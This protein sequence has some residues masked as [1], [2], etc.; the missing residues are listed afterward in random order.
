M[1]IADENVLVANAHRRLLRAPNSRRHR[2]WLSLPFDAVE[3]PLWVKSGHCNGSAEWLLYPQKRTLNERVEM[4][5]LCHKRTSPNAAASLRADHE[6]DAVCFDVAELHGER[7]S[8]E[9]ELDALAYA[10]AAPNSGRGDRSH[11]AAVLQDV[12]PAFG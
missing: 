4:S 3:C 9:F 11:A 2:R 10:G 1:A 6:P 7:E 8:G 5:A 12:D